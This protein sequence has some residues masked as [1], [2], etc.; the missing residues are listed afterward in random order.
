MPLFEKIKKLN[1]SPS[2]AVKIGAVVI[3]AIL[4]L[5]M[6]PAAIPDTE[7]DITEGTTPFDDQM[8]EID[9]VARPNEFPHII[10][11]YPSEDA[12]GEEEAKHVEAQLSSRF[13]AHFLVLSDSE[14]LALDKATLELYHAHP[15]LT[16]NLGISRL[17]EESYL[18]VLSRLGPDGLEIARRGNRIDITSASPD[19][20]NEG[21]RAFSDALAYDG[22]LAISED[23]YAC[24]ARP[25][26]ETSLTP[27]LVSDGEFKVLTFSYIDSNSYTLRAIEG[28]I[29]S[30]KP[31]LV[32]FNGYVDGGAQTRRELSEL[33]QNI[34]NILKK[35]YTPWCFT[36]GVLS[37][38]LPLITVCEV[39]SSFPGCIRAIDG[40]SPAGFTLTVG[41]K[42]GGIEASI[43]IG[44]I[45][46]SSALAQRIKNDSALF[47]RANEKDRQIIAVLPALAPQ[48]AN[49]ASALPSDKISNNLSALYD[50]LISAGAKEFICA[51]GSVSPAVVEYADGRVY[52]CGSIGFDALGIGG[53][54]DY[55]NSLRCGLILT[56]NTDKEIACIYA[57][58]LGLNER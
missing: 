33:W 15:S 54:F 13:H 18:S 58:D 49:K 1:I 23:L 56:L 19:R 31:D 22:K 55:N 48:M 30:S 6:L 40:D 44:D 7:V 16:L 8:P 39:I 11:I 37:G 53:R 46:D 41:K 24:D 36:P 20:I 12:W 51:G 52:L 43:Y 4:L 21:V 2:L 9:G 45:N 57:A 10:I 3:F 28:I 29:A 25:T 35:T 34:S 27:D 38:K 47:D 14:Y 26:P 5:T 42:D 32:I 50:S 17:L